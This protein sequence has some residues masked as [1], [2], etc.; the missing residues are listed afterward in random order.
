VKLV[1]FRKPKSICSPSYADYKPKTNAS[2]LLDMSHT[3]GR[4]CTGWTGEESK[5]LNV[6]DVITVILNSNL[7]LAEATMGRGLGSTEDD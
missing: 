2:M 6:V 4:L 1:R 3:E 5:N 7:K